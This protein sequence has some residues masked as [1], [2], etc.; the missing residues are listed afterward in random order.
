MLRLENISKT[1]GGGFCLE[2]VSLDFPRGETTVLIGPSGCG[3]STLLKLMAGLLEPDGG[4]V[5]F[6][7]ATLATRNVESFRRRMGYVIQEGGL[8]PHLSVAENI[9]L[10]ARFLRRPRAQIDDRIGALLVLLGLP[11]ELLARFPREL[12]GGQRQRVA[13]ARALMLDPEVLLLDEPLGALDPITRSGLQSELKQIFAR[14]GKTVV[15]VTHDM[16]EAAHFAGHI[17][18]LRDGRIVQ[19]GTL[20]DLL[21][22]PAESYVT[23]FIHA[24]RSP[25]D[26]V[27]ASAG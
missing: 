14:L 12:S 16:G 24:Q 27:A 6:D 19:R 25:L 3:K 20:R 13:L 23:D 4:S 8:F 10:V 18:L 26:A 5:R 22:C 9:S 11:A 7:G 21:D 1:L 17:V 2:P 15:L